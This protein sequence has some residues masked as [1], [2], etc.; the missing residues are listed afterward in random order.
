MK[1]LKLTPG[2]LLL[3]LAMIVLP[4]SA[5]G[6][7]APDSLEIGIVEHLNEYVPNNI[8]LINEKGDTVNLKKIIDKPTV[9]CFV[10]FECPMLCTP[11]MNGLAEVI[12]KTNM[13]IGKDYQ[14]LTIGF[15]TEEPLSLA[16]QKKKNYIAHMKTKEAAQG[17]NFFVSDSLNI[18]RA[19]SAFGF[20]YKRQGNIFLHPATAIFISPQGKITRYL[21][22]TYFLPFEFRMA[23]AESSKG[24]SGPTINKI[25][26]FCYGYDIKSR[27][28]SLDVTAVGGGLI[29]LILLGIVFTLIFKPMLRKKRDV[30][31]KN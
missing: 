11:L 14:V 9:L 3:L 1:I 30:V 31:I 22:G 16:I 13:K 18:A 28:Y 4:V 15:N 26:Q 27:R 12:D 6:S 5:S 25:L 8:S 23:I 20:R 21:N 10:Y 2:T 24:V 7:T 29:L 17:W 19:T